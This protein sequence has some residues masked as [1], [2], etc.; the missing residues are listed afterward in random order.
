LALCF[1][2]FFN[3]STHQGLTQ[4][5]WAG[6]WPFLYCPVLP[7]KV[8]GSSLQPKVVGIFTPA[9]TNGLTHLTNLP[10]FLGVKFFALL[11]TQGI[12]A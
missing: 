8:L 1:R 5:S 4:K 2:S 9:A 12:A 11:N 6:G 7:S 3:A 10:P